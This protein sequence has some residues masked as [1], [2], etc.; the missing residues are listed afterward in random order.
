MLE[1]TMSNK[2]SKPSK[3]ARRAVKGRIAPKTPGQ[4]Y[5]ESIPAP[6]YPAIGL[7]IVSWSYIDRAIEEIIWRLLGVDVARGRAITARQDLTHKI[8]MLKSLSKLHFSDEE[9]ETILDLMGKAEDLYEIRNDLAHGQWVTLTPGGHVAALSL[10]ARLPE[11]AE[12]PTDQVASHYPMDLLK[13]AIV[14]M[15]RLANALVTLRD[16][17][18]PLP[19]T[20]SRPNDAE[21]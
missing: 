7:G 13:G 11:E 9:H 18:G 15:R 21:K 16:R 2:S 17:I 6:Y 14:N 4:A 19:P 20:P 8:A 10:R 3:P 5:K 1:G 12:D